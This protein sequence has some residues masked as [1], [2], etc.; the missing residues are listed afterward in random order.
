M[1]QEVETTDHLILW[2]H[3]T[4]AMS[5]S[6]KRMFSYPIVPNDVVE[7]LNKQ[8]FFLLSIYISFI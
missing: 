6:I 5:D 7:L 2:C 4:R 1:S 3:N 8:N